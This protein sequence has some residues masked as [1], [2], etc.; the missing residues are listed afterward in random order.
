MLGSL[1]SLRQLKL[2]SPAYFA[3]QPVAPEQQ[4]QAGL[5]SWLGNMSALTCLELSVPTASGLDSIGKCTNL[6][7]LT[8]LPVPDM[9]ITLE[10]EV[11]KAFG[12]LGKLTLLDLYDGIMGSQTAPCS[13]ALEQLTCLESVGA[14]LWSADVLDAFSKLPHLAVVRGGWRASAAEQQCGTVCTQVTCL[15]FVR[16]DVPFQAFP[17]LRKLTQSST[18]SLAA[19]TGLPQHC[20][21]LEE[22]W[23]G[24]T[25][26]GDGIDFSLSFMTP[27]QESVLSVLGFK[28]CQGNEVAAL[29][30]VAE[31]LADLKLR[32]VGMVFDRACTLPLVCLTPLGRLT[33]LEKLQV[34]LCADVDVVDEDMEALLSA[35]CRVRS[36][37]LAIADVELL[38]AFSSWCWK[39]HDVVP[40]DG[41]YS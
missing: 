6:R 33:K 32:H 4:Q 35:L 8:L 1:S 15:D 16:G 26:T 29:V 34:M 5:Y 9:P 2:L 20:P 28:P 31:A 12:Q 10:P 30:T 37:E 40:D 41:C 21:N 25:K 24:V 18:M 17:N 13:D 22:F 14:E 11:F 38:D 23:V 7:S 19:F 36:V 27:E 3:T 39:V